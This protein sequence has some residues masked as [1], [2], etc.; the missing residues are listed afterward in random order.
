MTNPK[1]VLEI[2]AVHT[3]GLEHV[4]QLIINEEQST[5]TLERLSESKAGV[6]PAVQLEHTE[7]AQLK[8]WGMFTELQLT[9]V[10]IPFKLI[11]PYNVGSMQD[12]HSEEPKQIVHKLFQLEQ[13]IHVILSSSR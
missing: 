6:Y 10:V 9:Q 8:H 4:M 12:V 13:E 2:Q 5:Q 1:P 11:N 7:L 3:V